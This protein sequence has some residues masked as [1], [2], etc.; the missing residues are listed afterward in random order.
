MHLL[1][2]GA[3]SAHSTCTCTVFGMDSLRG[4]PIARGCVDADVHALL[5][6][7]G[8]DSLSGAPSVGEC[9]HLYS[10]RHGQPK[11]CA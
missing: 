10:V 3:C 8:M 11:R 5:A 1:Y 6:V 9:L 7:F 4:A 2:V